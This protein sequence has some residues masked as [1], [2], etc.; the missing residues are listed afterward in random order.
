ME[1]SMDK[2]DS[3][4]SQTDEILKLYAIEFFEVAD[5]DIRL[6]IVEVRRRGVRLVRRVWP[7]HTA[8]TL[9]QAF[10]F[11]KGIIHLDDTRLD[12]PLEAPPIKKTDATPRQNSQRSLP[13]SPFLIDN[14]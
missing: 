8:A 1:K 11:I 9:D 5:G 10:A 3:Q 4:R 13:I 12:V 7:V 2:I 6:S 14:I